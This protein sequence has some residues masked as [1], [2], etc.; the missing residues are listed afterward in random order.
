[1]STIAPVAS[2]SPAVTLAPTVSYLETPASATGA[3]RFEI[4][5]LVRGLAC[6][7]MIEWHAAD[8]WLRGSFRDSGAFVVIRAVGGFA[9]PL[10]F[11][12]AGASLAIVM[13]RAD[14]ASAL[15]A[16]GRGL[17][18]LLVGYLLKWFS[19]AVDR[20]AVVDRHEWPLVALWLAALL[21][22]R[23]AIRD[24]HVD[25]RRGLA[26]MGLFALA[27]PFVGTA[28][29]GGL[30]LLLRFDVLQGLGIALMV[31]PWL[32][33]LE[34]R[35]SGARTA[36]IA[37]WLLGALVIACVTPLW[38][39][40]PSFG[41]PR[42]LDVFARR[43]YEVSFARF[44][45]FPWLAHGL[46]GVAFGRAVLGGRRWGLTL[47]LVGALLA[48]LS[49][50]QGPII[51]RVDASLARPLLRV[52]FHGGVLAMTA[53]LGQALAGWARASR[54]LSLFGRHSMAV[55]VVHLE[56]AYGLVGTVLIGASPF[57]WALGVVAIVALMWILCSVLETENRGD[58]LALSL[59]SWIHRAAA[60]SRHGSTRGGAQRER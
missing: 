57:T 18:V 50:D 27:L 31:M 36:R 46:V 41:L 15:R 21:V 35:F 48:Y 16:T 34:A 20:G 43:S 42:L 39:G 44:P 1:M 7:F 23:S 19:Y 3:R 9:A 2:T 5:D 45:L 6:L 17:D 13:R 37:P 54:G 56:F 55:Y 38:I 47:G 11:Q 53:A 59:Q 25:R 52:V 14:R 8:A 49:H 32:F 28:R 30:E 58:T 51:G 60:G 40:V 29:H 4:V 26:S 24:G 33:V 22:A 10:F 12:L